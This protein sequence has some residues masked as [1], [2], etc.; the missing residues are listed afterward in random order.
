MHSPSENRRALSA[1]SVNAKYFK[2]LLIYLQ[3]LTLCKWALHVTNLNSYFVLSFIK[4]TTVTPTFLI[5]VA[6]SIVNVNISQT[7]NGHCTFNKRKNKCT[8]QAEANLL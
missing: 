6:S 7:L 4:V 8:T 3:S 2:S 1:I 5:Y